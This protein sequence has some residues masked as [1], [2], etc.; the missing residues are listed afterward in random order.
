MDKNDIFHCKK[1][2]PLTVIAFTTVSRETPV[3]DS[4]RLPASLRTPFCEKVCAVSGDRGVVSANRA[5]G[6]S[7]CPPCV[8]PKDKK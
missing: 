4:F 1:P 6:S 8:L 2:D 5:F 3:G 7:V